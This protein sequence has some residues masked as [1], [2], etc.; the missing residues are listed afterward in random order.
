M[1]GK[2]LAYVGVEKERCNALPQMCPPTHT[3]IYMQCE[4]MACLTCAEQW[5]APPRAVEEHRPFSCPQCRTESDR[6]VTSMPEALY[7]AD[8]Q[9]RQWRCESKGL[10]Q[11]II[12]WQPPPAM[13]MR[14][15]V[16]V[17]AGSGWGR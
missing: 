8:A 1:L 11:G 13:A 12:S 6:L 14:H 17:L 4:H 16:L 7:A 5:R 15:E 10:R 3:Y 9:R 2:V